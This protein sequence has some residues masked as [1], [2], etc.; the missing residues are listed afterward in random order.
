MKS[1][2]LVL[3]AGLLLMSGCASPE[4]RGSAAEPDTTVAVGETPAQEEWPT[5]DD[6]GVPREDAEGNTP[7]DV[8]LTLVEV[9]DRSD[10]R[11]AYSLY[12]NHTVDYATAKREWQEAAQTYDEFDVLETRI[13]SETEAAV[14]VAYTGSISNPD[15]SRY[16]FEVPEPGEWWP[17]WKVD[18]VWRVQWM[19]RQ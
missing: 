4:P 3:L 10:W 15:G 2:V 14:R 18:G 13:S 17:L 11:A 5:E 7:E 1:I 6:P 19:P 8:V 9:S 16:E 12:T